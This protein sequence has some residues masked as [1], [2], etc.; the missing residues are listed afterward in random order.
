MAA[1]FPEQERKSKGTC[2][3]TS[4]NNYLKFAA[5][6][7]FGIYGVDNIS[8]IVFIDSGICSET[9]GFFPGYDG[10]FS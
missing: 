3:A 8:D 9:A 10:I 6:D 4:I 2:S 7:I 1:Q 5:A